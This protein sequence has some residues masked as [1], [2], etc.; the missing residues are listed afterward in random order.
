M[1]HQHTTKSTLWVGKT[2]KPFTDQLLQNT[3]FSKQTEDREISN[4]LKKNIIHCYQHCFEYVFFS[5]RP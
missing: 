4:V 3:Q 5:Y 1:S 2:D